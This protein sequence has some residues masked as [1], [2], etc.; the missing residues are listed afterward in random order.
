MTQ[1]MKIPPKEII[2]I[3]RLMSQA[4][5]DK[6]LARFHGFEAVPKDV[7]P[8]YIVATTSAFGI[9]ITLSEVVSI[10]LLEPDYRVATELQAFSRHN[11][12]GNRN[13]KTYSWLFYAEGNQREE[14]I[15]KNNHLRKQ[16]GAAL[17]GTTGHVVIEDDD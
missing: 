13:K 12:Q 8:R 15:R 16:I 5:I 3:H 11:R 1:V 17:T 10:G 6:A 4:E 14:M 2:F 9:G 7:L